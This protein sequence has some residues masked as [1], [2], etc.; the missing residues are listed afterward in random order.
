[1]GAY[2]RAL[3]GVAVAAVATLGLSTACSTSAAQPVANGNSTL[4]VASPYPPEAL[5]PHG[6]ASASIGTEIIGQEIYSRLVRP[7][8][9]GKIVA[10][11][12]TSWQANPNATSFTFTLRKGAVFS[13]GSALDSADVVDS[14]NRFVAAK[15]PNASNFAGDT[16]AA[17]GPDSVKVTLKAPDP[18]LLGKLTLFYIVPSGVQ[19]SSFS[20]PV[21]SG[22]FTVDSFTPGQEVDLVPNPKYYGAVPKLKK[23]I[24]KV[25]PDISAEMTA[26]KTGE[27]QATWGIPDDQLAQLSGNSDIKVATVPATSVYTMWFNS[28]NPV[29]SK[30]EVRRALW[31]AVDFPTI[32]KSLYPQTGALS[33]SVVAPS[34]LGYAPQPPVKY[35]PNAA[36]AALQAAGFDFSTTLR[37][38]YSGDSY[39]QFAQAVVAD[40]AKIGVKVDPLQ[41]E[42]AVFLKDLLA[43][44]WDINFQS[45][46][47]P[48]YDAATNLGRLYTCAAKRNGY[49]NPQ[50]DTLLKQAGS[51][52]DVNQRKQLYAQA[53]QIIWNDAVGMY[54]MSLKIAYAYRSDVH[55]LV[56]DPSYLPDFAKVTVS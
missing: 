8:A 22:P 53:S 14:F 49:C 7:D 43:L 10:D 2:R 56:P 32:I 37:F 24:V 3:S 16:M 35:D 48:T 6:S 15:G 39:S 20:K 5:D 26:L 40:L 25:I 50:L 13:D 31:Q 4:T 17:S 12:A 11:L 47:T 52:S 1:M 21:G 51:T 46:S 18:A 55:G 30:P 9:T 33:Q 54:P 34:V 23:L 36:K 42:S 41:K 45:L 44:N 38:Q 28:S 29:L 19:D 27:I